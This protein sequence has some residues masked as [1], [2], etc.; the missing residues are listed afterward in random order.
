[1]PILTAVVLM[2]LFTSGAQACSYCGMSMVNLAFPFMWKALWLLVPWRLGYVYFQSPQIKAHPYAFFG[3]RLAALGFLYFGFNLAGFFVYLMGSFIKAVGKSI[4]SLIKP[5]PG[6]PIRLL[7]G[8]QATTLLLFVPL[9]VITYIHD[10]SK[11][12]LDRLREYVYPGTSQ[13]RFLAKEIAKDP[14]LDIERLREMLL[15]KKFGDIEKASEILRIRKS[16]DDLIALQDTI[17]NMPDMEISWGNRYW[18]E[19]T[20]FYFTSWLEGVTGKEMKTKEE[21]RAWISEEE[22][23][24]RISP[25]T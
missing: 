4:L 12:N 6:Q 8:L 2:L 22:A 21:L 16:A 25:G 23:R 14:Q 18:P 19:W 3:N 13:S 1:M 20:G 15:S 11:D 24:R 9:V 10:S 17:L 7:W 5:V